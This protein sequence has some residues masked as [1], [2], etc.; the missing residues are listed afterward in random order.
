MA[1]RNDEDTME[2][3]KN[4][5]SKEYI[6]KIAD[7]FA[8]NHS[9]FNKNNFL[10]SVF[11]ENWQDRE[12]KERMRHLTTCLKKELPKKYEEAIGILVK[13]AP[14]TDKIA[15]NSGFLNMFFPDFV[16]V[17]GI[18]YFDESMDALEEF[19]KYSSSEFAIRPFIA[20]YQEKTMKQM[21][22]WA[23]SDNYHVRRLAS[24]GCRSRLPWAMALP[25]F[26]KDPTLILPILENLKDDESEYVRK[27]VA[28][29]LND[30]SKDNPDIVIDIAKEWL[31]SN[32]NRD[33]L[34]KH[35]CR[36]LLKAGNKEILEI[37]GY[38]NSDFEIKELTIPQ[39][40]VII[41]EDLIFNLALEIKK[42]AKVRLEYLVHYLKFNQKYS[43]KVFQIKEGNFKQGEIKFTKKHSFKE[44]TTR[45]H[46]AG[47][48]FLALVVNGVEQDRVGFMVEE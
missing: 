13:A 31:G 3:L 34:V 24:E 36:T 12:L 17:Y 28:N 44:M 39:K 4:Y 46:Y 2:L 27:S 16:E 41:G 43:A 47:E 21:L 25:E 15:K 19:T 1:P 48:H 32:K 20:K 37:F 38:G 8:K 18:D 23:K 33:K 22:K 26:K 7:I 5:Y 29:N 35:A 30:I 10:S 45:K 6:A 40:N 11:D 9:K 42:P 14:K